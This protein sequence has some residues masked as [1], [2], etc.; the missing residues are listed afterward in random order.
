[1]HP[2]HVLTVSPG[3]V[4]GVSGE[5]SLCKRNVTVIAAHAFGRLPRAIEGRGSLR[6]LLIPK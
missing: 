1:M 3:A 6:L 5:S 2:L 4:K